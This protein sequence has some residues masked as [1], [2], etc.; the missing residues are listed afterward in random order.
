MP[1][2]MIVTNDRDVQHL[3]SSVRKIIGD[4]GHCSVAFSSQGMKCTDFVLRGLP[5]NALMHTWLREAAEYAFKKECSDTE[6]ESMKRFT[7]MRCYSDTKQPFLVQTL[8]N[9]E[10]KA[11][12]I[13]VTSSTKWTKGEM[14]YYLDWMQD[15]FINQGLMLEAKG[16]YL[17]L[18][19]S[20]NE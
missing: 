20:Q 16:E 8:I 3:V 19:E 11:S 9:P 12:K 13:D 10:T 5:Q 15:F 1:T 2:S 18:A 14:S 7:K 4:E 17:E 6:L